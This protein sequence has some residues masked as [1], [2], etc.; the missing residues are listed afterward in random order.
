MAYYRAGW[1]ERRLIRKSDFWKSINGNCIDIAVLEWCKLFAEPRGLHYWETIVADVP[2]F[3][4]G[5]LAAVGPGWSRESF[6][7]Y[8]RHVRKY[9]D[10]FVAHLDDELVAHIPS[11]DDCWKSV[12]FYHEYLVANE[13]ATISLHGLPRDLTAYYELKLKEAAAE[14]STQET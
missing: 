14:Y 11:L 12:H 5:L 3:E 4:A 7:G 6:D 10:K 1:R 13:T 2:A 8:V 9:R